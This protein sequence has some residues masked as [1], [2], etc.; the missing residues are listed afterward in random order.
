M[1][2][3]KMIVS[4][5]TP[6][7]VSSNVMSLGVPT[8]CNF[9]IDLPSICPICSQTFGKFIKPISVVGD[10]VEGGLK[11]HVLAIYHCVNCNHVFSVYCLVKSD[12]VALDEIENG[13]AEDVKKH[14]ICENF[15]YFP[16]LRG[17]SVFSEFVQSNFPD[18]VRLF[19]ESEKAENCGLFGVCGAGY[20]RSLEFLVDSYVRK[21]CSNVP[22][23]F[24][25]MSLSQKISKGIDDE[26]IKLLASRAAW[27]GND[28]TH[29]IRKHGDY[30]LDDMKN[31]IMTFVR[32]CEAKQYVE[33]AKNI[34]SYK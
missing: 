12:T 13:S 33:K 23:G 9:P 21:F 34:S 10:L 24:S 18:F 7:I 17:S 25:D 27:L 31:F 8:Y 20:R 16:D 22:N 1:S 30:S 5:L 26:D 14:V 6:N 19:V 28:M 32:L 4:V 11:S 15:Q 3:H 29:V 2:V